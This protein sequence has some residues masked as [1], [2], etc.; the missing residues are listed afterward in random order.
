MTEGHRTWIRPRELAWGNEAQRAVLHAIAED[1]A[2]RTAH[3]VVALEVLRSDGYLEF[4]AIA[5]DEDARAKMMG[6]ASPLELGHIFGVLM[7]AADPDG[8]PVRLHR[9]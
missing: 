4:V 3:K 1:V 7:R 2:K 5:G 8:E 9:R 6:Q